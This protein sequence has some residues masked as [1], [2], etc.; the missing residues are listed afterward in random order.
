[1]TAAR[2]S[3]SYQRGCGDRACPDGRTDGTRA[4]LAA[5]EIH[6]DIARGFIRAEVVTHDA[7]I[8]RGTMAAC[9]E[10]GA[11]RLEGKK[12]IVRD[13]DIINFQFET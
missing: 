2:E 8:A 6:S 13:G 5:G 1:M 11:V 7:L 9:R 12:F 3:P 4:Q 10:H